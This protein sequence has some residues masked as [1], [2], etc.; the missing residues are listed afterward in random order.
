MMREIIPANRWITVL[1][2]AGLLGLII[3]GAVNRDPATIVIV[4]ALIV[5]FAVPMALVFMIN[6]RAARDQRQRL[7]DRSDDHPAQR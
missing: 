2:L 1:L 7:S 4:L 3:Y 6:R 5:F